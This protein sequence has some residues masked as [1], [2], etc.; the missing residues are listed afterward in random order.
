[1]AP[2]TC[3]CDLSVCPVRHRLLDTYHSA[4][5]VPLPVA[6]RSCGGAGRVPSVGITTGPDFEFV[7]ST[8][9]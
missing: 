2:W 9:S 8:G 7:H 1:M 4:A 6:F 5:E 3:M